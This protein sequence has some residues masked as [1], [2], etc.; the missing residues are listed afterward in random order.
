MPLVGRLGEISIKIGTT[1]TSPDTFRVAFAHS[2]PFLNVMGD[3][4]IAWM[5]LWRAVVAAPKVGNGTSKKDQAFYE[6]QVKTAEFYMNSVVPTI[7]GQMDSIEK[8]SSAAIE[9][10]EDAFGGL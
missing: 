3:I 8:C 4:I 6:G 2:L 10:G 5:L 1:A 9:I 7:F